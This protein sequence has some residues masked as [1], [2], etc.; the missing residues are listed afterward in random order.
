MVKVGFN[1]LNQQVNHNYDPPYSFQS[2]EQNMVFNNYIT[3][4]KKKQINKKLEIISYT[5]H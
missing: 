2:I 1:Y 5:M 4:K 3:K